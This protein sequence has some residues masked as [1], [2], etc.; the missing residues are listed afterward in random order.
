LQGLLAV[1]ADRCQRVKWKG[2]DQFTSS[3]PNHNAHAHGDRNKSFSA[4][5]THDRVLLKCHAGC[6]LAELCR[7]LA[8]EERE[9]F[10]DEPA[11]GP[12]GHAK[13]HKMPPPPP[14]IEMPAKKIVATY[15][16]EDERGKKLFESVRYEPKDF[17]QR[18][19]GTNG[20]WEWDLQGVRLVLFNLPA[21]SKAETVYVV[22]G[23]KDVLTMRD[24]FS[25]VATTNPMGAGKWREE[26]NEMLRGKHVVIIPDND[27]AGLP[28]G[29]TI[30]S[31]VKKTGKSVR[32]CRLPEGIKDVSEWPFSREAFLEYV[33]KEAIDWNQLLAR[34]I[35]HT[36][37][38]WDTTK[39]LTFAI[40]RFYQNNMANAIAGLAGHGKTFVMLSTAKKLL[41]GPGEKLWGIFDVVERFEH[42]V[43]LIPEAT[44]EVLKHRLLLLGLYDYALAGRL[45]VRTLSKGPMVKLEDP[46]MLESCKNCPVF[47]DTAIRFLEGDENSAADVQKGLATDIFNLL[48]AGAK[49]VVFAHHSPKNLRGAQEMT[50]ENMMRGSAD[51][52]ALVG[53]AHG[54]FQME[55]HENILHVQNLKPANFEPVGPFQLRGR[56]AI[57]EQHDFALHKEP[58]ICGKW[59]EE[60]PN[61]LN[62]DRAAQKDDRVV[63][64]KKLFERDANMSCMEMME[65]FQAEFGLGIGKSSMQRYR[66]QARRL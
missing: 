35:Y 49:L 39:P 12:N 34:E 62:E 2:S 54:V 27:K 21:V 9:L 5:A 37:A 20:D 56:P 30:A 33:D 55:Q 47:L 10:F 43:Y 1:I 25:L 26:F 48:G 38:E 61:Q 31:G 23:E 60:R 7:A 22:E 52:G 66:A 59:E 19:P 16:Y 40:D 58:G 57:D 50:L 32:M 14:P 64:V 11:H 13:P 17:R 65:R 28:H 24:K 3:C 46:R 15:S 41:E 51:L 36:R 44:I 29:D 63:L 8:L 4:R 45:L 18:R 53:T 42:V 6:T